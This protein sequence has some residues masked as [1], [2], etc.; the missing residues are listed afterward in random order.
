MNESF[1][2]LTIF[3]CSYAA[4]QFS[5]HFVT[6]FIEILPPSFTLFINTHMHKV[7]LGRSEI[8]NLSLVYIIEK[9]IE[10]STESEPLCAHNSVATH[11]F[12]LYTCV[13]AGTLKMIDRTYK[14]CLSFPVLFTV[15][16]LIKGTRNYRKRQETYLQFCCFSD[17]YKY[18]ARTQPV[19]KYITQAA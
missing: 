17:I 18:V 13:Y 2:S 6:V 10:S 3:L 9:F 1:H 8:K 19:L 11:T 4:Y 5:S 12:R 15:Q 16:Y 14:L 7:R